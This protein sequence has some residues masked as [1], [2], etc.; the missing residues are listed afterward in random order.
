MNYMDKQYELLGASIARRQNSAQN[1][2]TVTYVS[3]GAVLSYIV[4]NLN[5]P[6]VYFDL[7]L[8]F[9]PIFIFFVV[10]F[11]RL[12]IIN[13]GIFSISAYMQVFLEPNLV[14]LNWESD[15]T[16]KEGK[17]VA[18]LSTIHQTYLY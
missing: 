5:T 1:L 3:V 9:I 11:T 6:D 13:D 14:G 15:L 18:F 8:L 10:I 2:L 7:P 4:S 12:R 17:I 16:K